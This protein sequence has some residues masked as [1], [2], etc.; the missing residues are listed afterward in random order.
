MFILW[1]LILS[2]PLSV[3]ISNF[4]FPFFI[5]LFMELPGEYLIDQSCCFGS[6]LL[7]LVQQL[8]C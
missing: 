8:D 5:F 2:H 3:K 4:V 1:K 7:L 6:R